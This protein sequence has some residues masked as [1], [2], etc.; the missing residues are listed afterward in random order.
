MLHYLGRFFGLPIVGSEHAA[1]VDKLLMLLHLLMLVLFIGWG[2]YFIYTLWRFRQRRHP[3][4]DYIGA[5]THAS[6]YVEVSVALAEMVLLFALAVPF[7]ARAVDKFPDEKEST[8]IR[9]VGRQF[10]WTARYPGADGKFGASR[11]ELVS[12]DNP[13]GLDKNDPAGKDD[14]VTAS[15][16]MAAPVG[17]PVIV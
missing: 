6:T 2:A 16:G 4:A 13:L 1:N 10:N 8:V 7:W 9:V 3:R 12:A 14:L 17:K 15:D 11:L 5:K